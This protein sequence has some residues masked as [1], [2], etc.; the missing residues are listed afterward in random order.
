MIDAVEAVMKSTGG[1]LP[2]S[3]PTHVPAIPSVL[4]DQPVHQFV[5][6]SGTTTLWVVFALMV[7]ASATFAGL[8]L[9]VPVSNRL[10]HVITTLITTIAAISYFTMATGQGVSVK[11]ITVRH[12]HE[13]VPDTYEHIERQIFWARYVDWALTTPLLLLDLGILAGL[14]GAHLLIAIVA[15]IIMVLMGMFA[16]FGDDGTPQK[17][18]NFTIAILAFLVVIWHL[19]IN[20]RTQ[21]RAKSDNV[22]NFYM[23][24]AAYTLILWAAYPIVWGIGDGARR[25]SVDGE[26]IAYAVL[27]VLAKGVFGAWLLFM[28]ARVPETHAKLDGFWASGLN[29][30][31]LVRLD[32]EEGA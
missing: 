25:L 19:A 17:W 26:I 24:I 12:S 32:D 2:T 3:V 29:R 15:D 5:G 27:D 20:G 31:G 28:H 10:Y 22:A 4:P 14:N 13:H 16:A 11:H 7:I 1:I 6:D 21:V 23:A 8:S 18:G 30:E 9:R